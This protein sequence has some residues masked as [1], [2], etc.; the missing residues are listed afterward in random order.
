MNEEF[1]GPKNKWRQIF[2]KK[3]FFPA[4]YLTI[5]AVLLTAVVWYQN[6]DSDTADDKSAEDHYTPVMNDE[7]A[8]PVLDQQEVIAMP[9]ANVDEAEIVTKFFDYDADQ[10]DR[11]N[12]LV[13]YNNRYYQSTGVDIA[14]ANAETFEVLAAISGTV[15]EVKEDPLLG[16]V[17]VLAHDEDIKTYYASLEEVSVSAGDKLTQGDKLGTAGKNIFGKDNGTHVHFEIRKSGTELNPESYFNQPVSSLANVEED[18]AVTEEG[19]TDEASEE[20]S[21]DV[22]QEDNAGEQPVEEDVEEDSDSESNTDE[23]PETEENIEE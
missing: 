1:K 21:N 11:Q 10:E 16:N 13:L 5:A 23:E 15:E 2:R 14:A 9:V 20:S 6:I 19:E 17:V 4:L 12:A 18:S 3:W 22:E 8:E 7:D